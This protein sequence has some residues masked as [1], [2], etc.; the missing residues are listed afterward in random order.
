VTCSENE[1]IWVWSAGDGVPVACLHRSSC[2]MLEG[3]GARNSLFADAQRIVHL[4]MD[5]IKVWDAVHGQE[6]GH[7]PSPRY[8]WDSHVVFSADG[9][10]CLVF[11]HHQT[12]AEIIAIASGDCLGRLAGHEGEIT[13]MAF[14]PDGKRIASGSADATIR[15]WDGFNGAPLVC[16]RGHVG[17]VTSVAFSPDGQRLVSASVDETVRTWDSAGGTER[18]CIRIGDPGVYISGCSAEKGEYVIHGVSA[19]AFTADGKHI[20]TLSR[21]GTPFMSETHTSRVWDERSGVCL[22]TLQGT[23][24]FPAVCCTGS[25]W[26]ASIRGPEVA[27]TSAETVQ[28]AGW[29]P[30]ALTFLTAHPAGRIWAGSTGK[31][32]Y[33]FVLEGGEP[34]ELSLST[35]SA[36][37]KGAAEKGEG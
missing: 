9:H 23:G 16:M 31:H 6:I 30:A 2:V 1:T 17:L 7:V 19:V 28:V 35:N 26:Q 12:T 22:K 3:G 10:R 18:A 29:F 37:G 34:E 14:S 25:R 27:I 11:E 24:S 33:H 5:G 13:C 32:M 36:E 4:S 8:F 21:S 20:V 15:L